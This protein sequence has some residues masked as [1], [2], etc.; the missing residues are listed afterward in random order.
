[1]S[2]LNTSIGAIPGAIPPLGGW[3]AATGGLDW[4]GWILFMILFLWQH[5]HFYAIAWMCKEDYKR[6]G[7][8][9]LPVI[10]PDGRRTFS[11][12]K[13]F[14]FL[15]IPVSLLPTVIGL[16]GA[17]YFGGALIMGLSLLGVGWLFT[18]SKSMGDAR[19][20]LKASVIYLPALLFLIIVDASFKIFQK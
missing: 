9:M 7:F 13:L 2:W 5:P 19:K 12:I 11:Q 6:A 3:A 4:G 1:M 15:L 18:F 20:L 17:L 8:K 14:S 16:S 10:E